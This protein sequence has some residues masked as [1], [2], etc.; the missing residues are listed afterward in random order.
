MK[1]GDI[2]KLKDEERLMDVVS[3]QKASIKCVWWDGAG[4]HREEYPTNSLEAVDTLNA[5]YG[6]SWMVG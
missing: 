6:E 2:V 5:W 1:I 3:V 4:I